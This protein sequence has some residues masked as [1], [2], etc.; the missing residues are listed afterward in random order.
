MSATH[1]RPTGRHFGARRAMLLWG[2]AALTAS[3]QPDPPVVAQ[4]PVL[5]AFS[6]NN[7]SLIFAPVSDFVSDTAQP[8]LGNGVI[9]NVQK[10]PASLVA[11]AA[12]ETCTATLIGPR[13][14]LTA[15]HCVGDKKEI[16]IQLKKG[17][18]PLTGTCS[19]APGWTET[20]PSNDI[21]L[22]L[23]AEPVKRPGLVYEWVSLDP[24]PLKTGLR[25]TAGGYGCQDLKKKKLEVPPVF[26]IG[27]LFIDRPPTPGQTWPNW[28]FAV[29]ATDASKSFVCPG[30]SGGAV[31]WVRAD[32]SRLIVAVMSAVQT[33][34]ASKD[35]KVSY[36][37]ALSTEA[38]K[39]FIEGWA[40]TATQEICGVPP[41]PGDC[42][43]TQM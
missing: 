20:T 15:A 35:F 34:P 12:G 27:P 9:A 7:G 29:A 2:F 22:C 8:Q 37:A 25:L 42:R 43:P 40:K 39:A 14:L 17:A 38:G 21:A 18:D 26:R 24:S 36:L 41:G 33:D 10:W 4:V 19:R 23:M 5:P 28:I 16:K 13:T 11:D 32:Q 30:D 1:P 3:A 31:Y 6:T